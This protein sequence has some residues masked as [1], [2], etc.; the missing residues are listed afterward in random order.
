LTLTPLCNY[1][2]NQN[3]SF[4][5]G[6]FTVASGFYPQQRF[7]SSDAAGVCANS[8]RQFLHCGVSVPGLFAGN[9]PKNLWIAR[10]N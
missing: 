6:L 5:T 1:G 8:S 9:G 4:E 7:L 3:F 2:S 10:R